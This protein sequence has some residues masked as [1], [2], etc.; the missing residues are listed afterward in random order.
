MN[1]LGSTYLTSINKVGFV[2]FGG[3]K[4]FCEVHW[5]S[6]DWMRSRLNWVKKPSSLDVAKLGVD[7]VGFKIRLDCFKLVLQLCTVQSSLHN[8]SR[9]VIVLLWLIVNLCQNSIILINGI[10][11]KHNRVHK[12]YSWCRLYLHVGSSRIPQSRSSN[13]NWINSSLIYLVLQKN[14]ACDHKLYA[15]VNHVRIN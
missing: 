8:H 3:T 7:I 10:V 13:Q 14:I 4:I 15:F 11:C 6:L 2:I 9:I 5:T 12:I 1:I